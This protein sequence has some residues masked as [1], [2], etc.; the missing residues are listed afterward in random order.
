VK[1]ASEV[2]FCCFLA[3]A[4][5]SACGK[6]EDHAK[7]DDPARCASCHT[8]EYGATKNPPHAGVRPTACGVCH[9]QTSWHGARIEHAWWP[10]TGAHARA[11]EDRA[12]AGEE[13]RVKC[14]WCH[15][16]DPP[17]FKGTPKECVACHDEDRRGVRDHEERTACAECHSTEAWKPPLAEAKARVEGKAHAEADA[18][19]HAD[20]H[21]EAEDAGA[22]ADAG[23][24]ADAG[25]ARKPPPRKPKPP[26]TVTPIPTPI[27]TPTPTPKPPDVITRPSRR[28]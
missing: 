12:L 27:P 25:A 23:V 24:H 16:G 7:S 6:G 17:V 14:F 18:G 28:H 26:P 11:A 22:H 9:V 13:K 3:M 2:A 21:A 19:A 20:G 15:R 1:S 5:L 10:L 4:A 8:P